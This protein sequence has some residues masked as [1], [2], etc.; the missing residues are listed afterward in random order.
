MA[1]K[2]TDI[3]ELVGFVVLA[4]LA[5]ALG[6]IFTFP[7]IA[8]WYVFLNKPIFTPPGWVFGPVWVALYLLMGVA[9]YLTYKEGFNKKEVR[10][11]LSVFA[12]QLCLNA[13]W[14]IVFFGLHSIAGGLAFIILL[15]L[16]IALNLILF[17]RISR[18]AGLLMVP[19]LAWVTFASVLNLSVLLLNP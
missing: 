12:C 17:Y 6:S 3:L 2:G 15:W 16:A 9:A 19:Y 5:G 8:T 4:E 14:S 13:A 11:A 1:E 10:S 7:S 18:T